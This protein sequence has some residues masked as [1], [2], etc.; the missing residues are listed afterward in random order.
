M[1]CDGYFLHGFF[2]PIKEE[3]KVIV[4]QRELLSGIQS[5]WWGRVLDLADYVVLGLAGHHGDIGLGEPLKC[6]VTV[7]LLL[8]FT[9]GRPDINAPTYCVDWC[10]SLWHKAPQSSNPLISPSLSVFYMKKYNFQSYW[11]FKITSL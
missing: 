11:V 4:S 8:I 6:Y 9:P 2:L 7:M 10:L 3:R 5:Q 1:L